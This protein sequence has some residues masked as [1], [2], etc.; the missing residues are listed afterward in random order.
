[1]CRHSVQLLIMM[2]GLLAVANKEKKKTTR[3]R[4]SLYSASP[5]GT[6]YRPILHQTLSEV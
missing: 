3:K 1:M 5:F 6:I 2:S 4:M